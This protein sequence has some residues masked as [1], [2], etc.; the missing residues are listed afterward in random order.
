MR[1]LH[2][3]G[4]SVA[5]GGGFSITVI[6]ALEAAG[7]VTVHEYVLDALYERRGKTWIATLTPERLAMAR[8]FSVPVTWAFG[9]WFEATRLMNPTETDLKHDSD[10]T[11]AM[12]AAWIASRTASGR[13]DLTLTAPLAVL[14]GIAELAD[15]ALRRGTP[16]NP[17]DQEGGEAFLS[18]VEALK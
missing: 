17:L 10:M 6:R 14:T 3:N 5:Q 16:F 18:A 4:G 2:R 15:Q 9:N 11:R 1:H 12:R 7:F 13:D 8:A